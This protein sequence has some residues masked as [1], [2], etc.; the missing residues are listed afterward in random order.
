[1]SA[2][3]NN[4]VVQ[5][6]IPGPRIRN[7]CSRAADL[8]TGTSGRLGKADTSSGVA[9]AGAILHY[10]NVTADPLL[11][12]EARMSDTADV[13]VGAGWDRASYLDGVEK[14]LRAAMCEPFPISATVEAPGFPDAKEGER[15]TGVCVAQSS[16]YWLVYQP[17]HDRFLCFWGTDKKR[18]SAPGVFGSPLGC[19]SACTPDERQ[20]SGRIR[21]GGFSDR[22][23]ESR[24]SGPSKAVSAA[25]QLTPFSSRRPNVRSRGN[26]S[27]EYVWASGLLTPK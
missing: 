1:M 18:L 26:P 24:Y 20:L 2:Y 15:I 22:T 8:A 17:E 6:A 4:A 19:W 27:F 16:G 23:S 11:R 7:V 5:P 12:L 3:P 9:I 10:R 21:N 13:Y 14:G 25:D